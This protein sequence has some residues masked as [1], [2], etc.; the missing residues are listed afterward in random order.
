MLSIDMYQD[1]SGLIRKV[2]VKGRGADIFSKFSL[3][4]MP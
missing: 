4:S 2:F 3:Y 1:E